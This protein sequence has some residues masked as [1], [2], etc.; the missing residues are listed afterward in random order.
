MNNMNNNIKPIINFDITN[1]ATIIN[2]TGITLQSLCCWDYSKSD[3]II[4]NDFGLTMFDYGISDNLIKSTV[5]TPTNRYLKL[6][7]IG[8][9]IPINPTSGETSGST[10]NNIKLNVELIGNGEDRYFNLKDGYFTGFFKL[11]GYDYELIPYRNNGITFD[12]ML[13]VNDSTSGIF[14]MLGGR[15]EDK[16]CPY[17]E[18]EFSENESS[19]IFT[20]NNNELNA[21]I[22]NVIHK[23]SFAL[24]EESTEINKTSYSSID[25]LKNNVFSFE[26]TDSKKIKL[27]YINDLGIL[28]VRE[29]NNIINTTGF[30]LI[31][32]VS[33]PEISLSE[34]Q[35]QCYNDRNSLIKIYVNGQ[36]FHIFDNIP[37]LYFKEYANDYDKLIGIPYSIT[38]GGG[39]FGLKYSWHFNNQKHMLYGGQD[40]TFINSYFSVSDSNLDIKCNDDEFDFNV[41]EIINSGSTGNSYI[42]YYNKPISVLPYREYKI[43]A[44]LFDSGIFE[45]NI[46][47]IS[48]IPI[49]D[50]VEFLIKSENKYN[51]NIPH[52]NSNIFPG[53]HIYVKNG[54]LY[55]GN[56]GNPVSSIYDESVNEPNYVTGV[57]Q[58]SDVSTS[59]MLRN[60]NEQQFINIGFLIESPNELNKKSLYIKDF[61]YE[62]QDIIVKDVNKEGLIIEQNFDKPFYGGI[63]KLRIYNSALSNNDI[64]S[65]ASNES[66]ININ[67][68]K[69]GRLIYK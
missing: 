58:W 27:Q 50:T 32:I 34:K 46:G 61:T 19:T 64:L 30:T 66:N 51:P 62:G 20:S 47:N 36:L 69:G 25:D 17:F 18:G 57:N 11:Q 63:Q 7:Q 53:E 41:I 48:L 4:L 9:N 68:T 3:N 44:M 67:V 14:L 49:S 52:V 26:I 13:F 40:E 38:W 5:L 21:F 60:S 59:F 2:P 24:P 12:T 6:E 16:Y 15:S 28:V 29:S 45:N 23:K 55:Y 56:T 8:Y 33:I 22:S 37:E 43:N 31:S 1:D 35:L 65:I 10:I 42:M 39:S 54:I